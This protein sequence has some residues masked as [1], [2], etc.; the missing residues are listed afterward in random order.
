MKILAIIFLSAIVIISED[1]AAADLNFG[2]LDTQL[3]GRIADIPRQAQQQQIQQMQQQLQVLQ[4]IEAL[5]AAKAQAEIAEVQA[6]QFAE[7]EQAR[8]SAPSPIPAIVSPPSKNINSNP[9]AA[10]LTS[11]ARIILHDGW[12]PA[13]I[14]DKLKAN[15][16]VLHSYNKTIG[17]GV[18][19]GSY[20]RAGITDMETYD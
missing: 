8:R 18:L 13:L 15:G 2:I 3:P 7:Q 12:E 1:V 14:T 4:Q 11:E 19:L 17:A 16:T 6:R 10:P 9:I 20:R 5:K